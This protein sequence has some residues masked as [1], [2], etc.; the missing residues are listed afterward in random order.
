M[1]HCTARLSQTISS[2]SAYI[3]TVTFKRGV[4]S[5]RFVE[6]CMRGFTVEYYKSLRT[7]LVSVQF[8]SVQDDIL[9]IHDIIHDIISRR[10]EKPICAPYALGSFPNVGFETVPMAMFV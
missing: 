1:H 9:D 6:M 5:Q 8:S 4:F 7:K 3:I 2:E 10:S